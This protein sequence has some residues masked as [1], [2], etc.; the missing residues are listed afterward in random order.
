LFPGGR[1]LPS[2]AKWGDGIG[3]WPCEY[4]SLSGHGWLCKRRER[5]ICRNRVWW[6]E[7]EGGVPDLDDV[8]GRRIGGCAAIR[9]RIGFRCRR[10]VFVV[11][12]E[13][14]SLVGTELVLK[15]PRCILADELL[16]CEFNWLHESGC[17]VDF[18]AFDVER[19]GIDRP[20]TLLEGI[21]VLVDAVVE[22]DRIVRA[23]AEREK[24]ESWRGFAMQWI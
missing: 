11:S 23:V 18:D 22:F 1:P 16:A 13:L 5:L 2:H 10:P 14:V 12:D 4:R 8:V 15:L 9:E 6:C 24:L 3:R 19:R 7:F 17:D 20:E 21:E